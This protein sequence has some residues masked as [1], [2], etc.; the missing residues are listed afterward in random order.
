MFCLVSIIFFPFINTKTQTQKHKNTNTK[1]QTHSGIQNFI[2][3]R[4]NSRS[5]YIPNT[6]TGPKALSAASCR[7]D[8]T[9]R[10]F[11][12]RA[13][14][15]FSSNLRPSLF[16]KSTHAH[17]LTPRAITRHR[18]HAPSRATA[19]TRHHARTTH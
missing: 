7:H 2:Q 14:R 18:H 19:T 11:A 13:R 4:A 5:F 3:N 12:A 6:Q 8:Q 15:A 9:A 17:H 1:T 10:S 16:Y